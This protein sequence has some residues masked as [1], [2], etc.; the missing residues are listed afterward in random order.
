M[1][2]KVWLPNKKTASNQAQHSWKGGIPWTFLGF[3]T[4]DNHPLM[5]S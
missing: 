4:P 5:K 2:I 1:E 3:R